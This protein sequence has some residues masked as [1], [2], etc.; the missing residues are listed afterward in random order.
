MSDD[1]TIRVDGDE[2]V[3]RR[4]GGEILVG[5]RNGDDVVLLEDVDASLFSDE[6]RAAFDRG[7]TSDAALMTALRGLVQAQIERGG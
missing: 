2:Y 4:D 7:D 1:L 3:L 5:R 6:A